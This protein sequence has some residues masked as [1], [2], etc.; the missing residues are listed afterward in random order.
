MD[1]ETIKQSGIELAKVVL[2]IERASRIGTTEIDAP[3]K[4][5]V[6]GKDGNVHCLMDHYFGKHPKLDQK[7][8][9]LIAAKTLVLCLEAPAVLHITEAWISSKCSNCG[10]DQSDYKRCAKCGAKT[11]PPS[12]NRFREE[13]LIA[14][15][16][17]PDQEAIMWRYVIVRDRTGAISDFVESGMIEDRAESSPESSPKPLTITG[18]FTTY[19]KWEAFEIPHIISNAPNIA[20]SLDVKLPD[21]ILELARIIDANKPAGYPLLDFSIL[22]SDDLLNRLEID[23]ASEN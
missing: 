4:F 17:F 18:R 2:E 19:W 20:L 13:A 5:M 1:F 10:G 6:F 9:A 21:K 23:E 12:Q 11:V 15:L 22:T 7:E 8:I 16:C 14:T 3:M